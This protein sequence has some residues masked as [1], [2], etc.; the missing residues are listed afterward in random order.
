MRSRRKERKQKEKEAW[1]R[2]VQGYGGGDE[3]KA[4]H[5]LCDMFDIAWMGLA[6]EEAAEWLK[7]GGCKE[8][9]EQEK[10][11]KSK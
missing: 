11:E 8:Y 7:E 6:K 5:V 2:F 10:E 4:L 3:E 9:R 1:E